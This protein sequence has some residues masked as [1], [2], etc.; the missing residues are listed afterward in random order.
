MAEPALLCL[1]AV[2]GQA[3]Q[4]GH[5]QEGGL[6]TLALQCLRLHSHRLPVVDAALMCLNRLTISLSPVA[7]EPVLVRSKLRM[8][9]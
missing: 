9:S 5:L 8:A 7:L 6:V 3:S 2:S 1:Q 4:V